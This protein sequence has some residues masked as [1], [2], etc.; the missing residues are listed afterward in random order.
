MEQRRLVGIDLGIATA[1]TVVVTDETGRVIARKRCS[2]NM[3]SLEKVERA[4]LDNA[5]EGVR[6]DVVMEP[7][8]AAWL[9]VAVFFVS[10]GHNVFRVSSAKA[11][12]LRRFMSRHAKSN[13]IDAETLAKLAVID[14]AN[15]V[16]LTLP[17]AAQASC[18]GSGPPGRDDCPTQDAHP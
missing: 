14:R 7:T 4:A 12:D 11:F 9:P 18:A 6:L 16:P 10:R 5:P 2:P 3:E 1:H 8:G 13:S 15:L 17:T